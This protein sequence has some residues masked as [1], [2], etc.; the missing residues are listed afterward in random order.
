M[1]VTQAQVV[2]RV[3]TEVQATFAQE[4]QRQ[5]DHLSQMARLGPDAG[6]DPEHG[7]D[8]HKWRAAERT[9]AAE[10]E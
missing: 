8:G 5:H 4:Q 2:Q 9:I 1:P 6:T 7:A 3:V 10:A